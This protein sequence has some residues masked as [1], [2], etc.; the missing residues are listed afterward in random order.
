MLR[1]ESIESNNFSFMSQQKYKKIYTLIL[2][3]AKTYDYSQNEIIQYDYSYDDDCIM[4]L[5]NTHNVE[6]LR[7]E[8]ETKTF[9]NAINWVSV[10]LKSNKKPKG[11]MGDSVSIINE[12]K[13]GRYA[14]NCYTYA[15]VLNDV[16]CA[17]GYKCKYIFCYP[18]DFHPIDCHVVNL[19][20]SNEK[21]KWIL[22]D[23]ANNVFYSD[24][25]G[26]MLDIEEMRN[27]LIN[28]VEINVNLLE[29]YDNLKHLNKTLIKQKILTYMIKNLYR[30]GCYRNS[31]MDRN[32][33]CKSIDF[34]HLVPN[35][36]MQTP[37]SLSEYSL[38]KKIKL[39]EHFVLNPHPFWAT[40]MLRVGEKQV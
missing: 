23:S 31:Q 33:F 30:F 35:T 37:Y 27:C 40:P 10:N 8:T 3:T 21:N 1:Q 14:A 5:K 25:Q 38:E 7:G 26:N 19:V 12:I 32:T 22:L 20:Y 11:P 16:L 29:I 2:K 34:Y 24:Y 17:L 15:V 6:L 28:D 9:I 39:T 13:N 36:Y 18:I 4:K